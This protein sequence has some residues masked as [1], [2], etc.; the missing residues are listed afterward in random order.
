MTLITGLWAS[1]PSLRFVVKKR[2]VY[3]QR[4]LRVY[5]TCLR[6]GT[7]GSMRSVCAEVPTDV[8]G[9]YAQRY[10][11]VYKG[12]YIHQGGYEGGYPY[13]HQGDYEG[14]YPSI[15]QGGEGR[16]GIPLYTR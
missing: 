14:G 10:P 11:R 2:E 3:A 8:Q 16:E 9:V 5:E 1:R 13:I 7:H 6:R 4:Y 15:H 12:G